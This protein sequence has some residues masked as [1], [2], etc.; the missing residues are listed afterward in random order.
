[1]LCS[2]EIFGDL[3]MKFLVVGALA[4]SMSL[5]LVACNQAKSPDQVQVDVAKAAADAAESSAK[6]DAARKEA[7]AQAS[8]QLVK[9]K[10]AAEAKATDTSVGA[11]A[12]AAVADAEG[13]TKIA[14]AKCQGLEG[15]AQRQCKDDANAHLKAVKERASAAKKGPVVP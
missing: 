1:M 15:D 10:A 4:A 14:L 3:T 9:D 2:T 12:D 11:V 5:G 8:D 6:A 13:E 7:E